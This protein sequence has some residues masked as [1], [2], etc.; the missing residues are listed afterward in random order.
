MLDDKKK[1][2]IQKLLENPEKVILFCP[3][4]AYAGPN[5]MLPTGVA[6]GR[7]QPQSGCVECWKVYYWHLV[8]HTPEKERM[9]ML[10]GLHEAFKKMV[11]LDRQGK[12][13]F[14]PDFKIEIQKEN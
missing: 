8:V 10:E 5:Q 3:V 11:E 7:T 9:E 12:W 2:Q 6:P 13:D 1:E 14:K 4:H